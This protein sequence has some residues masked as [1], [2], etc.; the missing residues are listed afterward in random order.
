MKLP[1]KIIGVILHLDK[2][3]HVE[4]M[5]KKSPGF[6]SF[7]PGV[8]ILGDQ[9]HQP[10]DFA[11]KESQGKGEHKEDQFIRLEPEYLDRSWEVLRKSVGKIIL[12]QL[13]FLLAFWKFLADN[14]TY[15]LDNGVRFQ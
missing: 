2:T 9:K 1:L 14:R 5:V 4:D 3:E 15:R 7:C 12:A 10:H 6:F 11:I 8:K 13:S